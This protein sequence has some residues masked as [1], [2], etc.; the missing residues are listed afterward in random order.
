[1][2]LVRSVVL[3]IMRAMNA[4]G[5]RMTTARGI[6]VLMATDRHARPLVSIVL[7][8]YNEAGV[9]AGNVAI[10]CEYLRTLEERYRF[11]LIIVDDG[12]RDDTAQIAEGLRAVYPN[13]RVLRHPTNFG[14]G[15]AFKT[16]FAETRGEYVVTMDVD[17][18]YAPEHIALLLEKIIA[19]RA[20]LV[21]AS[22]YMQG[23]RLTNVPT[24]R[25]TLSI[26]GNR[27]LRIFARGNVSTL[28]C[29]VRA[30]DGP[31][32]RSL[33]LRALS[34]DIMPEVVYKTMVMRGRIEEVPAH[35]D[36]TRQLAAGPRRTSSMRI[37]KHVLSTVLSGFVFRPFMFLVMPGLVLLAF[38]AYVNFWMFI[39]FFN[40]LAASPPESR[41][42]TAAFA[43]A[44]AQHPHTFIVALLSLMLAVQL[45]GLGV[46]ALQSK[47]YFEELYYLGV[48][49]RRGTSHAPPIR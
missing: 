22:P 30:Y 18:S 24:L 4:G 40:A 5:H 42:A 13:L 43:Q 47:R 25:R 6:G 38:S 31:F 17:L 12:S 23:G 19:T 45:I 35:L 41:D 27:F 37:L 26:W 39:H 48:T 3:R 14:L 36:W 49:V 1:M 34:M 10:I 44:Y 7:P 8:A 33:V 11:E 32:I 29:M 2:R 9:L 28:T 21:L 46:V 20:K 16:A 15:Q